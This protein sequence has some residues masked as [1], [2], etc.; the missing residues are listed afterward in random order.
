MGLIQGLLGNLSE[1]PKEELENEY[2]K[3]LIKGEEIII[4]F[5]LVRDTLIITNARIISFDKQGATGKKMRLHSI[6]LDSICEVSC[7]TAG[8]G[9]DDSDINITYIS[10]PYR[11]AHEIKL[12]T[13]K[14][15]FPKKSDITSLYVHLETI[16]Y[17]NVRKLNA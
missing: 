7:E 4:G 13:K 11:R 12:S 16:A 10:S 3:Y 2:G 5:K 6:Y 14:Y 8:F 1:V 17:K 9:L 15:E